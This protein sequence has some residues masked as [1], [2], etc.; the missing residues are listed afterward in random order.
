[1]S[2]LSCIS[3]GAIIVKNKI[4]FLTEISMSTAYTEFASRQ[5]VC[6]LHAALLAIDNHFKVYDVLLHCSMHL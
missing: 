4:G 6:L 1:M 5:L 2:W 3:I